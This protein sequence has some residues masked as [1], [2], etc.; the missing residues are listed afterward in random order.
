M[1]ALIDHGNQNEVATYRIATSINYFLVLGISSIVQKL[2]TPF[3]VSRLVQDL[4]KFLDVVL[5][6]TI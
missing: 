5:K 3:L 1:V 2:E 6:Y 4:I